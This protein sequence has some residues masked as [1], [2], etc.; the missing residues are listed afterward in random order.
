MPRPL[1]TALLALLVVALTTGL[2]SAGRAIGVNPWTVALTMNEL[3]I[4]GGMGTPVRCNLT[5][6]YTLHNLI[7]KTLGTLMGTAR[8]R[9][10]TGS[11]SEGNA[12]LL[13][14][15]RRVTGSQGPYHITYRFYLGTLPNVTVLGLGLRF[16]TFWISVSGIDCLTDGAVD[17]DF[18]TTG[19]NPATGMQ[20][21]SNN[22]PL[23]GDFLC[24]FSSGEMN[25][26]GSLSS[27]VRMT[28][29]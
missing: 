18:E 15:G 10:S 12:G 24:I 27:S 3:E 19:G 20:V 28:L 22:V 13:V 9:L 2:A 25:G 5:V 4:E 14:G 11:C 6:D 21:V 23:T 8:M 7:A 17:I 26:S 1:I 29:F 16:T